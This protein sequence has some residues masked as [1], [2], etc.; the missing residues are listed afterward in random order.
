MTVAPP[1]KARLPPWIKS[2]IPG[3]AE[4]QRMKSQLRGLEVS[5]HPS[6]R[7]ADLQQLHTVCEEARCPNIAEC[8]GGTQGTSTATVML[9]GDTCTRGC[10]FCA[11][12]VRARDQ[13]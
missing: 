3:G 12:K 1:K 5:A 2:Q 7:G 8:W 10:R 11:V 9:M 4:F 6:L 13:C